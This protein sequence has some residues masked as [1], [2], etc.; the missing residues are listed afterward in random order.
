[1][2]QHTSLSLFADSCLLTPGIFNYPCTFRDISNACRRRIATGEYIQK[3]AIAKCT[4]MTSEIVEDIE[5]SVGTVIWDD[6][7]GYNILAREWI[8][9]YLPSWT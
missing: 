5:D 9:L 3:M 2:A 8:V 7:T 4:G 1:M 6:Y